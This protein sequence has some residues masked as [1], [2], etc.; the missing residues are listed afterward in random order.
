MLA[1]LIALVSGQDA[2][3]LPPTRPPPPEMRAESY[4]IS[5]LGGSRYRIEGRRCVPVVHQTSSSR[6]LVSEPPPQDGRVRLYRLL[7]LRIDGCS[8]ALVHVDHLPE[9][10]RSVGRNLLRVRPPL[11]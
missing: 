9:A 10:D 5:P 11:V 8:A 2:A 6:S 1:L 3:V 4:R 7:D